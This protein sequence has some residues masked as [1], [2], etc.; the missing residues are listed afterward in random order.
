MK[1]L[2][3]LIVK[4]SSYWNM[5][6]QLHLCEYFDLADIDFSK[7][8]YIGSNLDLR[9][10]I[11]NNADFSQSFFNG[12]D[13]TK[14]KMKNTTFRQATIIHGD[15]TEADISDVDF[16]L[17]RVD[18]RC[19]GHFGRFRYYAGAGDI[20]N[21]TF[22]GTLLNNVDMTYGSISWTC[23]NQAILNNVSFKETDF[24]LDTFNQ[25][26]L[27]NVSFY[28]AYLNTRI[29]MKCAIVNKITWGTE[30]TYKDYHFRGGLGY[31]NS[32]DNPSVFQML[33]SK[34]YIMTHKNFIQERR[35]SLLEQKP[36]IRSIQY[37]QREFSKFLL[38][39]PERKEIE[40]YS[41]D[42]WIN[43]NKSF[44]DIDHKTELCE[45]NGDYIIY[46][47][48]HDWEW[49]RNRNSSSRKCPHCGK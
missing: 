35:E 42:E 49:K 23:F 22:Q 5:F 40:T 6:R 9:K 36:I 2:A 33:K 13:F 8:R 7:Y 37:I 26:I 27:N 34:F 47:D 10:T 12:I 30:Y 38:E 18:A 44:Y 15:F 11:L 28:N 3:L 16:F 43:N 32:S 25:T 45:P 14:A 41:N 46:S 19:G 29:D 20:S 4:N 24:H 17:P 39:H 1:S 31:L 21:C 48:D